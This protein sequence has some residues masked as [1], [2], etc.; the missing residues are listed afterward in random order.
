MEILKA[1][2]GQRIREVI[3]GGSNGSTIILDTGNEGFSI[4][5]YCSWRLSQ[6][7][8]IIATSNDDSSPS[9]HLTVGIMRLK[10]NVIDSVKSNELYDI[11]ILF[12]HGFQLDVFAN[13]NADSSVSGYDENWCI[14][15]KANNICYTLDQN[16]EIRTSP[17]Y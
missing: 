3:A 5:I 10:E 15:D 14:A 1:F 2:V 12:D 7:N 17:Y 13:I 4:F 6:R 16:L 11:N 8:R 9:G